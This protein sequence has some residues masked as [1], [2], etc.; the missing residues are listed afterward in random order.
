[1]EG[2]IREVSQSVCM[3][4]WCMKVLIGRLARQAGSGTS[5]Y[6]GGAGLRPEVLV[7]G[8]P[9]SSPLA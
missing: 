6:A 1:M 5:T 9:D 3:L 8:Q 2:S 7:R 4:R